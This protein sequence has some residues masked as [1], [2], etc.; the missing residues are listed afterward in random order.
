[1]LFCIFN[2]KKNPLI[3]SLYLFYRHIT[4]KKNNLETSAISHPD[5]LNT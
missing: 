1:M 5:D 2:T 4:Y 3:A